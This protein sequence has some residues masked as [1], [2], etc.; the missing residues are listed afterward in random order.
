MGL[1]HNIFLG[2]KILHLGTFSALPWGILIYQ[3]GLPSATWWQGRSWHGRR[4]SLDPQLV[5]L[6]Q[7]LLGRADG[8]GKG[9]VGAANI[10]GP[11][12]ELCWTIPKRQV[13]FCRSP[14]VEGGVCYLKPFGELQN[15][16]RRFARSLCNSLQLLFLNWIHSR[17]SGCDFW[18]PGLL[19]W[20]HLIVW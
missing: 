16:N 19:N 14:E 20:A 9:T 3:V 2:M 18:S 4:Q 13:L 15:W 6:R 12:F 5:D 8:S 11:I 10:F 17:S 7:Q 1:K